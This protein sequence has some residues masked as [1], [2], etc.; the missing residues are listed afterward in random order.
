LIKPFFSPVHIYIT[1]KSHSNLIPIIWIGIML[2][3]DSCPQLTQ[4]KKLRFSLK[5]IV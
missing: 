1:N 4:E 3:Y 5:K 2:K